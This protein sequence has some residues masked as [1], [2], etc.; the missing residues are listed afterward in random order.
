VR[1][2]LDGHFEI[3]IDSNFDRR[4]ASVFQVNP[5]GTQMD[6]LIVDEHGDINTEGD[7]DP[8]WDGVWTSEARIG[9]EGWTA[10]VDIP[11]KTLNIMCSENITWGLNFKRFV[12]RE[13]DQD[14]WKAFQ[15]RYGLIKVSAAGVLSGIHDIGSGR[16]FI[17]KAYDLPQYDR[18]NGQDPRLPFS[19]GVDIKYGLK[20]KMVLSLTGNTDFADTDVDLQPFNVTPFKVL[21]PGKRQF[22]LENGGV[23]SFGLG[24]QDQLFFSCNVG[25]DPGTGHQA[26][27]NGGAK[28]TSSIGRTE[29]GILDSGTRSSG[30]NPCANYGIVRLKE[31][32][33]AGSYIGVIGIEKRS[34]DIAVPFN[35]T[36]SVDTRMV[37]FKYWFLDAHNEYA[38]FPRI[39][40]S[41]SA[42]CPAPAPSSSAAGRSAAPA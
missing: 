15:R 1:Q 41:G 39:R 32:L 10:T 13:N 19:G 26:A 2:D 8:G 37:F 12:R 18:Q 42:S 25:I 30:P 29:L 31:S 33:W 4:S 9:S 38:G 14:L 17:V 3:M 35:Q 6:G 23:F 34:G 36:D 11:F 22:F 16:L 21:I 27:I 5:L 20:S 40:I 24:E 7:F 28:L